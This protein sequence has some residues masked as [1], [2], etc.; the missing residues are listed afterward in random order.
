MH[1]KEL[2]SGYITPLR[3][4]ILKISTNLTN[5]LTQMKPVFSLRYVLYI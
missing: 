4:W 2:F 3:N 1:L 5:L